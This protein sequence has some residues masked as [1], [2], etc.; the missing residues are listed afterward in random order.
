MNLLKLITPTA[1]N[2]PTIA[3]T[4]NNSINVNALFILIIN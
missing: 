4:I 1:A 2:T 3:T